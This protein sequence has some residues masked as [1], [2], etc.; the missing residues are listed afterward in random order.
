MPRNSTRHLL[1]DR[2]IVLDG[3]ILGERVISER[4]G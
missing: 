1:N 2:V 4:V 3:S